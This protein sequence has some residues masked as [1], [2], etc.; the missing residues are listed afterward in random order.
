[1]GRSIVIVSPEAAAGKTTIA[2]EMAIALKIADYSVLL[3]DTDTSASSITRR[4]GVPGSMPTCAEI[5][6]GDSDITEVIIASDGVW[7]DMVPSAITNSASITIP[8]NIEKILDEIEKK[9]NYDFVIFDTSSG[10]KI[11]T[12]P[13]TV[14]EKLIVVASADMSAGTLR[15]VQEAFENERGPVN[16]VLNKLK[17]ERF[18]VMKYLIMETYKESVI[19]A[20]HLDGVVAIS[21]KK[22]DSGICYRQEFAIFQGD[23]DPGRLLYQSRKVS[24]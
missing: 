11:L 9:C 23:K 6:S 14:Y 12:S 1:M 24:S 5:L 8:K 13:S 17:E 3:V 18:E 10:F 4:I 7:P 22:K 2:L 21:N 16:I 19:A 20:V 15:T